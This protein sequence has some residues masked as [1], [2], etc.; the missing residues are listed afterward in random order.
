MIKTGV[1]QPGKSPSIVSGGKSTM[2]KEGEAVKAGETPPPG[3]ETVR[4][5]T[6]DIDG[7]GK[8]GQAEPTT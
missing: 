2:I 1:V 6:L 3:E 4:D 8:S 7:E 5:P